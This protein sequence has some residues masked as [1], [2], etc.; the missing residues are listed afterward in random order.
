MSQSQ[1]LN[2]YVKQLTANDRK[3]LT[4]KTLKLV[5]EVG[6]LSR[7]VLP[8]E[9][10]YA[11]N[12]RV[13]DRASILEELVDVWLVN[14]SILYSMGFTDEEFANRIMEKAQVW[15]GLQV[16]EDR[17]LARGAA[18]PYEIHVTIDGSTG[19]FVDKFKSDCRDLGVKPIVLALQDTASNKVMT[20]VMTSSTMLAKASGEV[21][22]EMARISAG[23]RERG[24]RVVREKIEAAWW[25]PRAPFSVDGQTTMPK[26]CY[27]ECHFNV[28]CTEERRPA[29]AAIAKSCDC[30]L[31]QN[32]FKTFAD[33]SFTVMLTYRSYD[34]M[35][36]QFE[37]HLKEVKLA[38]TAEKFKWEKE[39]VE[40]SIYDTKVSH[41]A[42]WLTS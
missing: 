10:A 11:T 17:A 23:L 8:F 31:S 40:F 3:T 34:K 13:V 9:G 12:H 33:G 16:R 21:F 26:D 42:K 24:Y 35:F 15:H 19:L 6:E 39:I 7:V 28:A 36:E 22:T 30:H 27:F 5:E 4:Q 41:D 20:D 32:A 14:Q 1:L 38:L 29:L 25:H 37:E 18:M 2:E